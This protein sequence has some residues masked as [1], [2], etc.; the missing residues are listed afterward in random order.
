MKLYLFLVLL[1]CA[2]LVQAQHIKT[3]TLK[4]INIQSDKGLSP[5]YKRV[6][7]GDT[8]IIHAFKRKNGWNHFIV[9]TYDFVGYYDSNEIPFDVIE[10]NLKK[11]PNALGDDVQALIKA[12]RLEV[13]ERLRSDIK[14]KALNGELKRQIGNLRDYIAQPGTIGF[15]NKEDTIYVVGYNTRTGE[16]ALYN[17]NVAGIYKYIFYLVL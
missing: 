6:G 1:T 7:V 15:L 5:E 9:E 11:L 17:D 2:S 12:K 13:E 8:V 14:Q 4:S 3:T 16:Y 10:K